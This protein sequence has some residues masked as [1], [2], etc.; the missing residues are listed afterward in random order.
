MV[1]FNIDMVEVEREGIVLVVTLETAYE[2]SSSDVPILDNRCMN[3]VSEWVS[4]LVLAV[5]P[6]HTSWTGS[7]R[8][9]EHR[10]AGERQEGEQEQRRSPPQI[11]GRGAISFCLLPTV[12]SGFGWFLSR[13]PPDN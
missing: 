6:S 7:V 3:H 5:P 2:Y 13:N 10:N 9:R 12:P 1:H 4:A 8:R 11:G